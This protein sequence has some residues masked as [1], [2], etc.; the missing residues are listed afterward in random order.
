MRTQLL[1]SLA[2]R[3][4]V[5]DLDFHST[6]NEFELTIEER[7]ELR[8]LMKTK[9]LPEAVTVEDCMRKALIQSAS[10]YAGKAG[11]TK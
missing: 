5:H 4:K 6:V 3:A 2:Q 7:F 9:V 8:K 1:R 10:F 11:E